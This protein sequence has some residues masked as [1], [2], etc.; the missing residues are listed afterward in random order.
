[1]RPIGIGI[2]FLERDAAN[3]MHERPVANLLRMAEKSRSHLRVKKGTRHRSHLTQENLYVLPARVKEL[4][5][6]LVF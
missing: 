5:R 4:H 1:M 3:S 2:G 6:A